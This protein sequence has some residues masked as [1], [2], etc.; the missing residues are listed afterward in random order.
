LLNVQ[1]SD[2]LELIS[3]DNTWTGMRRNVKEQ[4]E[5]YPRSGVGW[6]GKVLELAANFQCTNFSRSCKLRHRYWVATLVI[7]KA[8]TGRGVK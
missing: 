4:H 1:Q 2:L 5:Q 7:Q 3:E 8:W 6:V